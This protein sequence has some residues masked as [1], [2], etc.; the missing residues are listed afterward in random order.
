MAIFLHSRE[1][2]AQGD[3]LSVISYGIVILP[4]IRNLKRDLPGVT[5]TLYSDDAG[6][7]GTFAR[8]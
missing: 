3:P 5:Q 1:V 4:L 8:T 2:V 7:L 6:S